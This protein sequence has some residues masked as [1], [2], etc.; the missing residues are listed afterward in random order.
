MLYILINIIQDG[1]YLSQ[2]I[3]RDYVKHVTATKLQRYLT[4]KI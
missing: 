4:I 2:I 1:N 3:V